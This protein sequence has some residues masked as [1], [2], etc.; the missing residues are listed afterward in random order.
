[1]RQGEQV[2]FGIEQAELAGA[3]EEN[4]RMNEEAEPALERGGGPAHGKARRADRRPISYKPNKC[5]DSA[6]ILFYICSIPFFSCFRR[7]RTHRSR[8]IHPARF[9]DLADHG[10]RAG[11][12]KLV[13]GFRRV[14]RR[15]EMAPQTI[16][17]IESAPGK[18]MR[19]ERVH[20]QDASERR[21]WPRRSYLPHCMRADRVDRLVKLVQA[22]RK[23]CR[24]PLK[25]LDW[26]PEIGWLPALLLDRLARRRPRPPALHRAIGSRLAR[27]CSATR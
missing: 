7:S 19:S 25:R 10:Q 2:S 27:Q 21:G 6:A 16:E 9:V 20:P 23:W 24:N 15:P 22:A 4:L 11:E 12:A 17:N 8:P 14:G 1:M 13:V 3:V 5:L 26:H 18:V